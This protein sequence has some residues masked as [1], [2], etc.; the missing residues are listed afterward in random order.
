MQRAQQG[1]QRRAGVEVA[2]AVLGIVEG[3]QQLRRGQVARRQR[4][5]PGLR[6]ADLPDRGGSL[7]FFQFQALLGQAQG[8]AGERDGAGGN[9]DH[10]GAAVAQRLDVGGDAVQP[11]GAGRRPAPG[12]PPGHCRF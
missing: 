4:L 10:L 12:P 8:P 3:Q 2:A 1:V 11:G 9:H 6:Q 7:F 5:A